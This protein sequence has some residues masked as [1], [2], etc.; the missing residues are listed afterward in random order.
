MANGTTVAMDVG[1]PQEL[2]ETRKITVSWKLTKMYVGTLCRHVGKMPMPFPD[3]TV[4]W[5]EEKI[6]D[7]GQQTV[8]SGFVHSYLKLPERM[9]MELLTLPER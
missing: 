1:Q 3:S 5:V 9:L 4:F 2:L 7:V 8:K 6:Q